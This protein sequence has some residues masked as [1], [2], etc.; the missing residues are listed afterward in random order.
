LMRCHEGQA[1]DLHVR[2]DRLPQRELTTVVR[3][4]SRLKTG[5]LMATAA[6]LGAIAADAPVEK[7]EAIAALGRGLGVGLQMLD[8]LSG[9]LNVA[10]RH[11]AIEDLRQGRATWLWSAPAEELDHRAFDALVRE[12]SAVMAGASCDALLERMRFRAGTSGLRG[13][14]EHVRGAVESLADA[15]GRGA[16]C[17]EVLE[18]FAW[19]ERRYV[20]D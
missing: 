15:I 4:I 16:W 14:R 6:A 18:Q 3:A 20:Q 13:A 9:V 12:L 5:S 2:V 11:K 8:D 19:L 10:R 1:L 17:D 7:V